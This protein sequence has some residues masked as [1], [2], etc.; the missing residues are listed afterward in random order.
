MRFAT[1]GSSQ[2]VEFLRRLSKPDFGY[3]QRGNIKKPSFADLFLARGRGAA[4]DLDAVPAGTDTP[5]NSFA[6][7][8]TRERPLPWAHL[9]SFQTSK[10]CPLVR[11]AGTK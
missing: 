4:A 3:S 11:S 10:H 2:G 6:I 9:L 5:N 8:M 1:C 7:L